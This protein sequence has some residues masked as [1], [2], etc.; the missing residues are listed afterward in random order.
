M[1]PTPTLTPLP[2]QVV[3]A[4]APT[5]HA[6][7][8]ASVV[9]FP[10]GDPRSTDERY[11]QAVAADFNL[12]ETAYLVPVDAEAEVP[13]YSLR[14]FTPAEEVPLCGHA[15][16]ASAQVL[17]GLHPAASELAFETRW[18]GTLRAHREGE[19][20]RLDLPIAD[21][22]PNTDV[23]LGAVVASALG[24]DEKDI[25]RIG[26]YD[27]GGP[28]PV[29]QLK[30]EVDLG[31]LVFDRSKLEDKIPAIL[32]VTQL[33]GTTGDGALKAN[34]RVF[35][36]ILEDPEDP[37]TGSAWATL[38]G[39]YLT[40]LGREDA[41]RAVG[42]RRLEDVPI[43]AHQLS[44]RGG[45]MTCRLVD[46]RAHLVGRGWRTHRGELEVLST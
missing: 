42:D 30:P 43:D 8:Q 39:Y 34:A 7:N 12:A 41:Q 5:P 27:Y 22:Q 18:R 9:L 32:V 23:R 10:A 15:T 25:L 14:W 11:L 31:K 17:F 2:Y 36:P 28:S 1:P 24:F 4:F 19:L 6:G 33:A 16:L 46:G 40:G 44:K 13:V 38:T 26:V 37:V 29:V 45:G 21:V 20:V 35:D 3:N